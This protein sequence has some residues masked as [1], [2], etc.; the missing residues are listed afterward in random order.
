[1]MFPSIVTLGELNIATVVFKRQE[2][3]CKGGSDSETAGVNNPVVSVE[4]S[5][6]V[7]V[8]AI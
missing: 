5:G 7:L 1:M 4:S 6:V 2:L 8:S 3:V